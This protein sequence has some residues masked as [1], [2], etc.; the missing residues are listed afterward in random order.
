MCILE[1]SKNTLQEKSGF[2]K[3]SVDINIDILILCHL[4]LNSSHVLF[5]SS[6][7]AQICIYVYIYIYIYEDS[8]DT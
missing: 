8:R 7:T 4:P 3:P 5:S 6:H 2:Y 1:Y